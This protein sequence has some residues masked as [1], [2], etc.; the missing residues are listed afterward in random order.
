MSFS[1][2]MSSGRGPGLIGMVMALMVLLGFGLLFMFAFDEG[3]QGGGQ[4]IQSV[5]AH[6]AKEI[7]DDQQNIQVGSELLAQVPARLAHAKE[8]NRLKHDSES[9]QAKT[10]ELV[11]AVA[12]GKA[13]VIRSGESFESYKDE[14]RAYIRNKAKDESWDQLETLA[15]TVYHHVNIREVTAIGIQIRHEGGQKRI[16]FEDLP[17]A[18]KDRFQFDPKQKEDALAQ[19]S[20][21]RTK[22]DAAVAVADGLT[23]QKMQQQRK[24]DAADAKDKK[25]QE[26]VMKEVQIKSLEEQVRGLDA[27]LDRAASEASAARAYGRMHLNKSNTISGSIKATQNRITTLRSEVNQLRSGL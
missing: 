4:S 3:L 20:E 24:V 25:R 7:I 21:T 1:D 14:Y 12:A 9:L 2:M 18:M 6:Q 23:D 11:N 16:P 27:E 5:I 15:G 19:E 8:L 13:E 17:E 10:A 22:H 26:I